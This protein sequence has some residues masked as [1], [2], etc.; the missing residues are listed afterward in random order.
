MEEEMRLK[1]EEMIPRAIRW[2]TVYEPRSSRLQKVHFFLLSAMI[3]WLQ[4]ERRW[5]MNKT[6]EGKED[7]LSW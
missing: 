2:L 6:L 7:V 5:K 3:L 1:S 4:V